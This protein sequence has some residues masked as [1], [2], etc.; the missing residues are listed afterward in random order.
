MNPTWFPKLKPVRFHTAYG[1]QELGD[2]L[3]AEA[4]TAQQTRAL[5][6]FSVFERQPLLLSGS[7]TAAHGGWGWR[8]PEDAVVLPCASIAL[9][10]PTV[11]CEAHRLA[12]L[13]NL[14]YSNLSALGGVDSIYQITYLH[15]QFRR[16]KSIIWSFKASWSSLLP[17]YIFLL[18]VSIQVSF[19][20]CSLHRASW[21]QI[22]RR[23]HGG[24]H[25]HTNPQKQA[26]TEG[27]GFEEVDG[28]WKRGDLFRWQCS[29]SLER[30]SSKLWV[31]INPSILCRVSWTIRGQCGLCQTQPRIFFQDWGAGAATLHRMP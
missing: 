10:F 20:L 16:G 18:P 17:Y 28:S 30:D 3:T 15:A 21:T 14:P 6:W 1:H 9:K 26:L 5:M 4:T 2:G 23:L 11:L 19:S 13:S 29:K 22:Q 25:I 8:T 31:A 7:V 27:K 12:L 24:E